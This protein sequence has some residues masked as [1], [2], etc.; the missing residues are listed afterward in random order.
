[1]CTLHV[2]LHQ[3]FAKRKKEKRVGAISKKAK[4]TS[5]VEPDS[6]RWSQIHFL[7]LRG[8][9]GNLPPG[10]VSNRGGV[11]YLVPYTL[12]VGVGP[13]SQ[14]SHPTLYRPTRTSRPSAAR[15]LYNIS[16]LLTFGGH[17]E[18]SLDREAPPLMWS[19]FA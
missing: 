1:M 18:G 19:E 7:S 10:K 6:L 5:T 16:S 15:D 17:R 11:K 4:L 9:R 8:P 13:T 2:R 14:L 12:L 3:K